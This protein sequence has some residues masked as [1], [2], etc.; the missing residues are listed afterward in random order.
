MGSSAPF[1]P[2]IHTLRGHRG[3][4]DTGAALR[5]LLENSP[6]RESHIEGDERVQDPYCIRCQPQVDGAC[7]DLLRMA[8][9]TLEIEA[10]AVT[11]NPLVL[12]DG[13]VVS[14]GNF[15]AEPVA[16]AADQIALAICEIGAIAQRRI[17]LAGRSGPELRPA[18]VPCQKARP[19]LRPDDRRS[20]VGGADVGKQADVASG[21]GRFDADLG[22][23]GRSRVDGLPWRAPPAADDGQS[24]LD[25]RHRGADGRTGDR[26]AQPAADQ[27]G[28]HPR[29]WRYSGTAVPT[30]DEDR[31][32]APDLKAVSD[33]VASGAL[34][35]A[36][37]ADILP[38]LDTRLMNVVEVKQGSSPIILGF[39]HTGTD[40]PADIRARLNENGQMLADTDWHIDQLYDGLAARGH[41]RPRDLPSLCDRC[42]SRSGRRQPLSRAK[43]HRAHSRIPIST[44][45]RSGAMAR[46]RRQR[47]SNPGWNNSIS[48][49]HAALAEEIERVHEAHGLV[50]LYDCHSIR[51]HIPFL[52]QGKLPDFNIGTNEGNSCSPGNRLGSR[53][54]RLCGAWL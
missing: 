14:G 53:P 29:A 54:Y 39:P 45:S 36:I 28:T 13:S 26:P 41:D 47:T 4:I 2:D 12:S 27:P 50:V 35:A 3:Q 52:F 42:Q 18:R 37:S 32:M 31:Y 34:N 6:I 48:P 11:D 23:S 8:A 7:L 25:H 38:V 24:V 1:H 16:F 46:S 51:S 30:L 40:V 19:Q 43:Y 10:N 9:R 20:H 21:L 22:Q 5:R 33:L 44:A 49:Y 17:A 15:H